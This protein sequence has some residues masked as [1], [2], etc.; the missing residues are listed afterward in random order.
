MKETC[1]ITWLPLAWGWI[2]AS[3][4]FAQVRA[5]EEL[6]VID[7]AS[8]MREIAINADVATTLTF[9]SPVTVVTGYGLVS[10]LESVANFSPENQVTL[11]HFQQVADD[12]IVLRSLK[13]GKPCFVTVRTRD[14]IHLFKCVPAEEANLAVIVTSEDNSAANQ[15]VE[16]EPETVAER[17][18]DQ[19]PMMLVG[20]LSRARERKFL[21]TVNPSLFEGWRERNDLRLESVCQDALVTVYEIQHWPER[22]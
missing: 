4:A 18:L 13:D 19:D 9:E 3:N 21:E 22:D 5:D 10:T 7:G 14:R 20:I 16:I 11:V 15:S 2:L 12:T 8:K 6:V 17:R 1:F